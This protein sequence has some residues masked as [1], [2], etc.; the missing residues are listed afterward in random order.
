MHFSLSRRRF[1]RTS[2][3]AAAAL[4]LPWTLE[5]CDDGESRFLSEDERRTLD[6]A[7][8]R[9]FPLVEGIAVAAYVEGLLTAFDA[10]PPRILA[11]GPFSGRTPFPDPATGQAS[12]QF[13]RNDFARFLPISRVRTIAWR[14]RIDGARSVAGGDFNA[15]VVTPERGYR[16]IY[17]EGLRALDAAASAKFRAKFIDLPE[18]QQDSLI[19]DADATFTQLLLEHAI[20]ATIAAPEYGGNVERKGWYAIGFEGDSQPLGYSIFDETAGEYRERPGLAMQGRD[21]SDPGTGLQGATLDFI[22]AVV[23]GA[24]GKRF[25]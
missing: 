6:A 22:A 19:A 3:A 25:Y 21:E 16:V 15:N 4:A 20:E 1:L 2:A 10:D 13:P 9:L 8:W 17:R 14:M 12:T 24:G 23:A 11:G 5:G 18:S 7:A